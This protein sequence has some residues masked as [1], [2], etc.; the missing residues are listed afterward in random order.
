MR[1]HTPKLIETSDSKSLFYL[2]LGINDFDKGG[3]N[4]IDKD[5]SSKRKDTG[6]TRHQ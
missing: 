5:S 6:N 3:E 2:E 4:N 1:N